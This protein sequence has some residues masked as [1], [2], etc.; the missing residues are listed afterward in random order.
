MVAEECEGTPCSFAR[1]A[2]GW[3]AASE[4]RESD[5]WSGLLAEECEGTPCGFARSASGWRAASERRES[6][7]WSGLLAEQECEDS[8]EGSPPETSSGLPLKSSASPWPLV[9]EEDFP[10][11]GR[12]IWRCTIGWGQW[13]AKTEASGGYCRLVAG[14][15]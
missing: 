4:L 15:Q 2:S 6:S 9:T 11:S 13:E 7:E 8:G 5:E 3:R 1:S 12:D 14:R 10:A